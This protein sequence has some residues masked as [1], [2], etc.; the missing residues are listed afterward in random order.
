MTD[1]YITTSYSKDGAHNFVAEIE[2]HIGEVGERQNPVIR[3]RFGQA[4][5]MVMRVSMTSP[6]MVTF[7]ACAIQS[8]P[9]R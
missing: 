9:E 6:V 1:R 8:T 4:R 5:H 3:R 2:H 7:V